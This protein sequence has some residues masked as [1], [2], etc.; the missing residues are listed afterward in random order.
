VLEAVRAEGTSPFF[1]VAGLLDWIEFL[2]PLDS[3]RVSRLNSRKKVLDRWLLVGAVG[4]FNAV[5]R[6]RVEAEEFGFALQYAHRYSDDFQ[7]RP[8]V[9]CFLVRLVCHLVHRD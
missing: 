1:G 9:L 8:M 4:P 5:P 6:C 7:A 2:N 3:L